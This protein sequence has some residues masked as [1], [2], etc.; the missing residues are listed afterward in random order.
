MS[1]LASGMPPV[2]APDA[3]ATPAEAGSSPGYEADEAPP[4]PDRQPAD[5]CGTHLTAKSDRH[6][7]EYRLP[8]HLRD[9]PHV[10]VLGAGFAGL[11]FAKGLDGRCAITV[12][13]R[14]NHHLFQPLLYQVGMA[15]LSAPE[16]AEPVRSIFR[17]EDHIVPLMATA[18][19]I[20]LKGRLVRCD[21]FD[22]KYDYLVCG[23]GGVRTF[24]GNDHWEQHAIPLKTLEHAMRMRR[25]VLTSFEEAEVTLDPAERKRLT[26]IVV[27][28]GGP[29]GVELAGAMAELSKQVFKRDFRNLD[30]T[31]SRIILVQSGDRILQE[32][33]EDLSAK[34]LT[35]L[36][37]LGVEVLF[38]QRV[39]DIQADHVTLKDGSRIETRNVLW[40]AGVAANPITQTLG[41]ELARGGRVPVD[42]DLS[43]ASQGHP[44]AFFVGDIAAI[45]DAEGKDVPGVAPAAI[46]MGKHVAKLIDERLARQVARSDGGQATTPFRYWDKGLMA[47]IG[48]SRAVAWT[49]DI[50]LVRGLK[51]S[52]FIAWLGWLFIHI[53][54]LVGFRN[55]IAV[56]MSWI[57]AYIGFRRGAR[58][59]IAP[60]E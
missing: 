15:A 43:L 31:L 52:G 1:V 7:G 33:P 42:E 14:Q 26:T 35:Q 32:Y 11:N 50:P 19:C 58:I 48:R 16:I 56:M 55:R 59:I 57:Y 25:H 53:M 37:S 18:E 30:P 6:R 9:L 20:D 38:G 2:D 13:D 47:T 34:A 12:V 23:L 29:T 45:T 46:Q 8:E 24:F 28:G 60:E 27:V 39:T 49:G 22:L 17:A 5:P 51:M 54:Y 36:E 21:T 40:G 4:R 10:V 41:I 44:E 3:P